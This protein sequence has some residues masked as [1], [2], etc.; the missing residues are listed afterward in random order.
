MQSKSS[1]IRPWC[2][3]ECVGLNRLPPRA[4]LMPYADEVSARHAPREASPWFR[5][6]NRGWR[7]RLYPAPETVPEAVLSAGFDAQDWAEIEVPA[8]WPALGFDRPIYTNVHMPF[9]EEPPAVPAKNPTG[10]YRLTFSLP[11]AWKRRRVV[12]HFGG[13]ESAFFCYV[14]GQA[15]GFSKDSRLPAEFDITPLV[16]RGKNTLAVQVMR[17]SDG[18]YL[19]DQDHW[20]LAGIDREVFLYSTAQTYLEDV[21]FAPRVAAD[22][23]SAELTAEIRAGILP[24]AGEG[25]T[26][27]CRL[28]ARDGAGRCVWK[29]SAPVPRC[30]LDRRDNAGPVICLHGHLNRPVLWSAEAPNLYRLTVTLCDPQGR[31][32]EAVRCRA[33]FRRLEIKQRE[34]LI[35][36]RPVLL[37]GVNRHDHDERL[38]KTCSRETMLR[39]VLLMKQFNLNA[40]RTSHYPND[41]YWY[42]LCD[43][44]GLY[45]IDEANIE[46]HH[47]SQRICREP[48]WAAAFLD[49][50]MRMVM[51]DK[52]HPCILFWSLGNESGYGPNHD[53]LAAWIRSY[54]PTRLLHYEGAINRSWW[55]DFRNGFPPL[56]PDSRVA[57]DVVCPMYPPVSALTEWAER[58]ADEMGEARPLIMCEYAHSMGNSTGN[59]K[60]Y[61]EAIESHHGLQ[62]GF[63]WDWVDQGLLCRDSRGRKYWAYG[64]D[65]DDQP[66]DRNFCINGLIWPDREPHP[67]MY[68]VKKV[69]QPVGFA[70]GNLRNGEIFITNKQ[71]FS[72]LANLCF[73]WSV[74]ADGRT[75][76]SGRLPPLKVAPGA[77]EPVHLPLEAR[78]FPA[79]QE[80][81]LLM[82]ADL[83]RGTRWA[84]SGHLVAWEQWKLPGSRKARLCADKGPATL[85]QTAARFE[86]QGGALTAAVDRRLGRLVSLQYQGREVLHEGPELNLWRAPLDNDGVKS[87]SGQ[88]GKP[89]GRWLSAGLHALTAACT[90]CRAQILSGHAVAVQS[91]H[92]LAPEQGGPGVAYACRMVVGG[93]GWMG[94]RY[95]IT[96]DPRLPDLPRIGICFAL[97]SG[98]ELLRWLGRGPHEN[99]IDRN[100]GA[101]VDLYSGTVAD[102]YV[103][104]ILPQENGNKTDV[105]WFSLRHEDGTGVLVCARPVFEFGTSHF[106][107][108]DLSRA[109]HTNELEPRPETHCT[110]DLK[111]RG[112][113]GRS[114][115]PDTLANYQVHPGRYVLQLQLRLFDARQD[116][117]AE[118]ARKR[119]RAEAL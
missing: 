83:R 51:R 35:N 11:T 86:L 12:L 77:T 33:G 65:F 68:E 36:N 91:R 78:C 20:R 69:F 59:L 32:V 100:S 94:L 49:R 39:D 99:Y 23:A 111:Q 16:K 48:R 95:E 81:F 104:Y 22:L 3:P 47:H 116:V 18:S 105:R 103:P 67:A 63:I 112:V 29:A 37:R 85:E 41:P 8:S 79:G 19:E 66:N 97:T 113:G 26:V 80:A 54:D 34:L 114:C 28:Y 21:F 117:D 25:W 74:R 42:E 101:P 57:T 70:A 98:F 13:V 106:T 14:N 56:P 64:G 75:V 7:F 62:G 55:K 30:D 17:W 1:Q 84:P 102:Q 90:D 61:W 52:N 93:E 31:E 118:L 87:W 72:D 38:G 24:P 119:Y 6:L 108:G 110:V 109:F 53:G 107:S 46:A 2:D 76:Q 40:V 60:E 115:G 44:Y 10:V 43:E 50:G 71:D 89:L 58:K 4:T 5:P 27:H 88:E 73:S 9:W 82:R 92:T 15:A 96:V 45:V